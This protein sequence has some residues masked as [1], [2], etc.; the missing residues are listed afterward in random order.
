MRALL[1]A[2]RA[3]RTP[4]TTSESALYRPTR[5]VR[6][7][8]A[9][10]RAGVPARRPRSRPAILPRRYGAGPRARTD[11]P[12]TTPQVPPADRRSEYRREASATPVATRAPRA[13][14][15]DWPHSS[16]GARRSRAAR[17]R[18]R[19]TPRC[20][21]CRTAERGH[22]ECA[23]RRGTRRSSA[24]AARSTWSRSAPAAASPIAASNANVRSACG[25]RCDDMRSTS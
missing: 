25:R 21:G 10:D 15:A 7:R 20:A 13:R 11:R 16:R 12:A 19:R 9:R 5:N 1:L 3:R 4:S 24:C 17:M 23:A 14:P 22:S 18:G 6:T 2:S 8:G